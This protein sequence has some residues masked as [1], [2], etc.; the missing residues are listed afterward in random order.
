MITIING[1][2]VFLFAYFSWTIFSPSFDSRRIVKVSKNSQD[3]Y[4]INRLMFYLIFIVCTAPFFLGQFSLVKYLLYFLMLLFLVSRGLIRVKIDGIVAGYLVFF[5]WL[6]VTILWSSAKN[7]GGMLLIKYSIPLLS[8][9]LGYSAIQEEY[10]LYFFAKYVTKC[11]LVYALFLGGVSAVFMPSLYFFLGNFFLTYAGLADYFTSIIGLFF[12]LNW[13][14]CT[15]RHNWGALWLLLSTL[16]EVVRTGLGGISIVGSMFSVI[17]YKLKAVPY[18]LLFCFMF[19]GIVLFVPKV[20]E[21][22]FGDKAGQVT[23]TDIVEGRAMTGDN[24]QT[25]GRDY[26]WKILLNKFYAPSP[27]VG[28]GLGESIHFMKDKKFGLTQTP[29]TLIHSD[30]VQLLCDTGVIGVLLFGLFFLVLLLKAGAVALSNNY[31]YSKIAAALAVA[32]MAGTAFS[33]GYDN[34]VSHSMTSLINPFIFIGFF[35]KYKE[36]EENDEIFEQQD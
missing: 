2:L 20:N 26:V 35:M 11:A 5:C 28:S 7:E 14:T 19:L 10:D 31:F 21:K 12:V 22:F 30:Y 23:A 4:Q 36:I 15:N 6:V 1:L 32:S 3:Y 33:M 27:V 24:I 16:L 25:S 17:R 8:L 13:L 29:I 9:W 34:V 18:I